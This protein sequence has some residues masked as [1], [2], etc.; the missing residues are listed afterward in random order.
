MQ[1][2]SDHKLLYAHIKTANYKSHKGDTIIAYRWYKDRPLNKSY[3][4][5]VGFLQEFL[6][7]KDKNGK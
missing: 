4:I 3:D 2:K 7:T 6:I 5:K 1:K